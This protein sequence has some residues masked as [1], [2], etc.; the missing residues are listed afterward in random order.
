MT[1]FITLIRSV[2][3]SSVIAVVLTSIAVFIVLTDHASY[4]GAIALAVAGLTFATIAK[5]DK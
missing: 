1:R 3:W 5:V 2:V 4:Q